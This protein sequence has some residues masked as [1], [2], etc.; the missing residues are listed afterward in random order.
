MKRVIF[1]TNA[2]RYLVT[3]LSFDQ[4]DDVVS[5]LREREKKNNI[6]ASMS[7]VVVK[8]LLAQVASPNKGSLHTK[9][10]NALKA[11]YLHC[12]DTVPRIL[13]EPDS[14]VAKY[15]FNV[16]SRKKATTG[17]ALFEI[18]EGLSKSPDEATFRRFSENLQKIRNFIKGAEHMYAHET[19]QFFKDRDPTMKDWNVFDNNEQE[20]K[21][22]LKFI[23]SD[24]FSIILANN[25]CQPI[26]DYYSHENV[27]MKRPD[28]DKW[29]ALCKKFIANFPEFIALYKLVHENV[30]GGGFN[31][32]EK[33]RA[34]FWW[35]TQLM[36]NVGDHRIE[37]DKLYFVTNDKAILATARKNNGKNTV[38]SFDEYTKDLVYNGETSQ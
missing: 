7:L 19:Y 3:G 15:I 5:Q 17:Q 4:I 31:L 32:F 28:G 37:N 30:L 29:E 25:Y 24:E 13:A 9:S 33:D 18:V 36:L 14:L 6:E 27:R 16:Q 8:E 23:R 26:F 34:N 20:R 12:Y 38:F 21:K 22:L 2:Y 1:D 10:L 11:M 35:D